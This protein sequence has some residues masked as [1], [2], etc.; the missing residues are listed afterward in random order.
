[1]GHI[2]LGVA[3]INFIMMLWLFGCTN[4]MIKKPPTI[5]NPTDNFQ[6]EIKDPINNFVFLIKEL[7]IDNECIVN[8]EG[9]C[10]AMVLSTASGL[11]LSADD[12]SVTILTAAHFCEASTPRL[13]IFPLKPTIIGIAADSPR[14][15]QIIGADYEN[16]LCLLK[17][18]KYNDEVF[19]PI[20]F[21]KHL[22]KIGEEV[23]AVA[24]PNGIGANGIKLVF[25]GR[26]AGCNSEY[27]MFTIPAT[28]G[29]SGG[30]IYDSK[31]NLISIV[32]AV[33]QGFENLVISPTHDDLK[34]F[35]LKIDE[36]IDIYQ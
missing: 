34:E 19:S 36:S 27:C 29:S 30:G 3:L 6:S 13:D 32:M 17:G 23:V 11:V 24:A 15:L 16:D 33:T 4:F 2:L 26:F 31:G 21:P 20:K 18:Y 25:D 7:K 28:F 14:E 5:V 12:Q 1:M 22:P 35:I 10:D 9:N 8:R